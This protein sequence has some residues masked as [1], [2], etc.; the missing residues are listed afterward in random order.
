[1]SKDFRHGQNQ[2]AKSGKARRSVHERAP[3]EDKGPSEQFYKDTL[4][5]AVKLQDLDAFED[6]DERDLP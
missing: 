1:M 4:R 5:H 6:Y 2:R 3:R